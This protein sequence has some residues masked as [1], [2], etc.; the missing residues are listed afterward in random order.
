MGRVIELKKLVTILSEVPS[1]KKIVVTC[2]CFEI[3]HAG[4]IRLL[5]IAK[6]MGDILIVAINSDSSIRML[7]GH[8]RDLVPHDERAYVLSALEVVDYVVVYNE[9]S[10]SE[11]FKKIC[12]DFLVKG[13]DY[14]VSEIVEKEVI[15]KLGGKVRIVEEVKGVS[16]S[17]IV[18]RILDKNLPRICS[19]CNLRNRPLA[20]K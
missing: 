20:M 5:R 18:E 8:E 2:G 6:S 9:C 11:V 13:G 17:L 3:L 14:E 12:P 7:K 16:T 4:H 10:A 19:R 15:E 1:H